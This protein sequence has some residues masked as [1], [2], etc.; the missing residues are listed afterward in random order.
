MAVRYAVEIRTT[1]IEPTEHAIKRTVFEHEN[2]DVR[3]VHE[4]LRI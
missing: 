4:H 1:R 3:N 2:D